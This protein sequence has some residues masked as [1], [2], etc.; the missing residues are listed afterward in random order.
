MF[1]II[2]IQNFKYLVTDGD[3]YTD[4]HRGLTADGLFEE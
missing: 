3:M 1:N 2:R 4:N